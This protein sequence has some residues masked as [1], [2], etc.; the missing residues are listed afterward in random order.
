MSRRLSL[1]HLTAI[2]LAPPD[3]VEAAARAGFDAVGLRLIKVTDASPGYP[4]MEDV[5][6]MRATKMALRNTG[7][8]VNDIEFVKIEPETDVD[9]LAG[10]LDA[11]AELGAREVICAPYDPDLSRL[12]ATLGRLSEL[13]RARG[14]G[15]SLEFFPWTV[16]PDLDSATRLARQ[17][18]PEVG[19]LVDALH[20]DRSESTK[21]QLRALPRSRL[22]LAHLCDAAV[23]SAYSTEDLLHAARDE[24]SPPGEGE[25]DLVGFLG[26]L[27]VDLPLGVE[28]PMTRLTAAKGHDVVLR[29]VMAA[30]RRVLASVADDRRAQPLGEDATRDIDRR[31]AGD[32]DPD[33]P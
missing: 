3:L 10:F 25:I 8:R 13:A 33:R 27:P 26:A 7:L 16:A 24:R 15:V 1:A 17:A 9:G 19:V 32:A 21:D 22:R 11:G 28:V 12:A 2:D 29:R 5:A 30:T 31:R 6:L 18:G 14:L 23:R 20:F 4:L